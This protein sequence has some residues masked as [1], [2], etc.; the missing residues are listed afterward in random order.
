MAFPWHLIKDSPALGD[1]LVEDLV[2]GL[3]M[4]L[5]GKSPL[6]CA[7]ARVRSVLPERTGAAASQRTRWEHGQLATLVSRGPKLLAAA[8]QQN[9]PELAALALDLMVP[10]LAL[11][12]ASLA[13]ATA[14]SG[15]IGILIRKPV[16]AVLPSAA[17]LGLVGLG[18]ALAWSRFA[19]DTV[20]LKVL[21]MAPMYVGWKV[22]MYF[23]LL[24]R[25]RQKAWVRTERDGNS[26]APTP[27]TTRSG[28][29]SSNGPNGTPQRPIY[30]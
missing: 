11:L 6:F 15:L 21:L 24:V 18:T 9:R 1:N 13:G 2:M 5:A 17:G 14:A 27:S 16:L 22:P 30:S 29:A 23:S 19:R 4:A 7:S 3:D 28:A 20:P 12:T 25:G 26:P 8:L 10:P